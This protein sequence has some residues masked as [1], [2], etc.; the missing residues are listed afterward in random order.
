MVVKLR[1]LAV[2]EGLLDAAERLLAGVALLPV[3]GAGLRR[4]S[5]LKPVD[6]RALNAIHLEAAVA[7]KDRDAIGTVLT[8]DRQLQ[9]GCRHHE[10]LVEA[11]PEA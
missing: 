4:A 7:L 6:V 9:R 8:Y 2:R 11:A 5:R 1:R 3:D 10:L